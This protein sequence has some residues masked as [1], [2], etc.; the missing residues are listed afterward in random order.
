M[1][2][3]MKYAAKRL[4]FSFVVYDTFILLLFLNQNKYPKWIINRQDLP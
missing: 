1:D 4:T 3:T 2:I